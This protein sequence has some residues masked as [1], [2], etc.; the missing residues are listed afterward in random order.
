M[1]INI[2]LNEI[3]DYFPAFILRAKINS[4][5]GYKKLAIDDLNK[6]LEINDEMIYLVENDL[7]YLSN[8]EGMKEFQVFLNSIDNQQD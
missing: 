1:N 5:H 8:L 7:F 3:D 6:A 2:F 4:I